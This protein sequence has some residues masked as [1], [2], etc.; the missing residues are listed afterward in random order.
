MGVLPRREEVA[1]T[2]TCSAYRSCDRP[3]SPCSGYRTAPYPFMMACQLLKRTLS[4]DDCGIVP[5]QTTRVAI[6]AGELCLDQV[7]GCMAG[8]T[9]E[10]AWL[11]A[12][13]PWL[14]G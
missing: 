5:R 3:F 1:G 13:L 10:A 12:L 8:C 7:P 2:R 4:D 14:L 9:M 11:L 6:R